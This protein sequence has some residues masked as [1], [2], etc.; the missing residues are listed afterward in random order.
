MISA[1]RP[2]AMTEPL[3]IEI[4]Y[5]L[6]EAYWRQE[7]RMPAGSSVAQ[8]LAVMDRSR[9]PADLVVDTA[10][11]AVYGQR[12]SPSYRLH[13]LDRI[14]VLRPLLRDPKD[15]RRQRAALNPL[16]KKKR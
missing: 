11:L 9:F 5:A 16:K 7:V 8:A 1:G 4:V 12:V 6:P 15:N 3:R 2:T 14:E 10:Y 13:D